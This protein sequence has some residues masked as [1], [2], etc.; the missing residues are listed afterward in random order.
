MS[1]DTSLRDDSNF[2]WDETP[3]A[4]RRQPPAEVMSVSEVTLCVKEH[5]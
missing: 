1:D 3:A 2:G 5:L 4:D